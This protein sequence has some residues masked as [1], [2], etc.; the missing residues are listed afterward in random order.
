M[1]PSK[2]M[3]EA[4]GKNKTQILMTLS[5]T[6]NALDASMGRVRRSV[7]SS[8]LPGLTG[9]PTETLHGAIVN[10][11]KNRLT[12]KLHSFRE[13]KIATNK[14]LVIILKKVCALNHSK[15]QELIE[16]VLANSRQATPEV[17]AS[18]DEKHE[19]DFNQRAW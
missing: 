2:E 16:K 3:K 14:N 19:K 4:I 13:E 12:P 1:A 6:Q 5:Q 10:Y 11:G 18:N 8:T 17:E 9:T 7:G 15:I